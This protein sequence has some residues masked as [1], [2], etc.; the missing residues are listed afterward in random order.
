MQARN[1]N[2]S[3]FLKVGLWKQMLVELGFSEE[4]V[5]LMVPRIQ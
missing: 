3:V 4:M 2:S 5:S 1:W